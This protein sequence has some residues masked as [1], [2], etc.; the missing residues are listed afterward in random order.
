MLL[1]H[2]YSDLFDDMF[3]GMPRMTE[4]PQKGIM[5]CDAREYDDRYELDLEMPGYKK[6]DI[7][8]SLKDGYLTVMAERHANDEAKDDQ[9]RVIRRERFS[10]SCQR[11]FYVGE[12]VTQE[13]IKAS[14]EDGVLRLAVPKK[15]HTPEV[16]QP[17]YI[18]I[19]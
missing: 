16:E 17:K 3:Y 1:S 10:G 7:H 2:V 15:V 12:D 4:R 6:E 8:A 11:S 13:D 19:Q 5:N 14:Y 18:A 9:G